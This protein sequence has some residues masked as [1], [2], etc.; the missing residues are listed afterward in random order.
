M[1][2]A[3]SSF[4][5]SVSERLSGP[6][7]SAV[8]EEYTETLRADP[9]LVDQVGFLVR[10]RHAV[11]E[12]AGAT[13]RLQDVVSPE[14]ASGA[15][16]HENLVRAVRDEFGLYTSSQVA[17][18]MGSKNTSRSFASDLRKAGKLFYIER[19]N[20]YQYPGFQFDDRGRIK[21]VI[22]PLIRLANERSWDVEDAGLW[23]LSGTRYLHGDRPVD[24]LGDPDV[25]LEAAGGAWSVEW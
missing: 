9:T 25:V 11:K 8:L 18:L 4:S 6:A 12:H 17:A 10:R 7:L 14:T 13:M 19:L 2:R 22:A 15:Q 20:T 5:S 23:L 16:A 3:A 1:F 21:P 24:H